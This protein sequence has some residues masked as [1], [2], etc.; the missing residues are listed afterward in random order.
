[1]TTTREVR[2]LSGADLGKTIAIQ[3]GEGELT[4]TLAAVEHGADLITEYPLCSKTPTHALGHARVRLE[5]LTTDGLAQA[6]VTPQHSV[7]IIGTDTPPGLNLHRS[8][9]DQKGQ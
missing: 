3:Y 7:T 6:S 1:M 8:V 2:Y 4:G 9:I 5:I